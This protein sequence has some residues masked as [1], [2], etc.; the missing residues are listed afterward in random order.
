MSDFFDIKGLA[1]I[2]NTQKIKAYSNIIRLTIDDLVIY[3]GEIIYNFFLDKKYVQ[4][5][6][7]LFIL[8]KEEWI[9]VEKKIFKRKVSI[10]N[11]NR[12]LDDFNK[13]IKDVID[14]EY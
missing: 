5:Y 1:I 4:K 11:I 14:S 12:Y 10:R 9:Q 13:K 7:R 3:E 8:I 2:F 6:V